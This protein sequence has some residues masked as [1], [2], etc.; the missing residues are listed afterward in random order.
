MDNT[1]R[2][3][4][5]LWVS[6]A[7]NLVRARQWLPIAFFVLLLPRQVVGPYNAGPYNAGPYNAE[8]QTILDR[9]TNFHETLQKLG[10]LC[11]QSHAHFLEEIELLQKHEDYQLPQRLEVLPFKPP[12]VIRQEPILCSIRRAQYFDSLRVMLTGAGATQATFDGDG[13]SLSIIKKSLSSILSVMSNKLVPTRSIENLIYLHNSHLDFTEDQI[14]NELKQLDRTLRDT[15]CKQPNVA[16]ELKPKHY[17]LIA[18]G[19]RRLGLTEGPTNYVDWLSL[20]ASHSHNTELD[21]P[22]LQTD[23]GKWASQKDAAHRPLYK[24]FILLTHLTA[25]VSSKIGEQNWKY[26]EQTTSE[27]QVSTLLLN[28]SNLLLAT[29]APEGDLETIQRK[30]QDVFELWI[31]IGGVREGQTKFPVFV[32]KLSGDLEERLNESF[33]AIINHP[34]GTDNLRNTYENIATALDILKD[35][36]RN[37]LTKPFGEEFFNE[38]SYRYQT[39]AKC[40]RVHFGLSQRQRFPSHY[41]SM[42]KLSNTSCEG[43][44]FIDS[45]EIPV[46]VDWREGFYNFLNEGGLNSEIFDAR[47]VLEE[48]VE[49]LRKDRAEM[50]NK[51]RQNSAKDHRSSETG[52]EGDHVI[53]LGQHNESNS[54]GARQS[55]R[56]AALLVVLSAAALACFAFVI[57]SIVKFRRPSVGANAIQKDCKQ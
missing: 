43:C 15:I 4:K 17:Q 31:E 10:Q 25:A 12:D 36:F 55:G 44:E 41:H 42:S 48:E 54:D 32:S 5:W 30:A 27:K 29:E 8:L 23:H 13:S 38:F 26:E 2:I 52:Q 22:E 7:T 6:A 39:F 11:D 35:I 56:G 3:A 57:L 34:Q 40:H 33:D 20:Y 37:Y 9:D 18:S 1:G 49:K 21:F 24:E 51:A 16:M 50:N 47:D 45:D 53:Y 14:A 28:L 46:A 19:L